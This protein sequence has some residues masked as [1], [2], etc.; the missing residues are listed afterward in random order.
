MIGLVLTSVIL[1]VF[2]TRFILPASAVSVADSPP[3]EVFA[4]RLITA[5]KQ[6][7]SLWALRQT[8]HQ[9]KRVVLIFHGNG[10]TLGSSLGIQRMFHA[11][12][13]S[14]YA[15]DYRGTGGSSGRPSEAGL[16]LD[17]DAAY[18]FVT[19]NE[20]VSPENVVLMGYSFG[21]GIAS[22]LSSSH[23]N[24]AL[25]LIA[26]YTSMPDAVAD[27]AWF[28]LLRPFV[29]FKLPTQEYLSRT[30]AKCVMIAH[31][32]SD[33]VIKVEHSYRLLQRH[34]GSPGF[35]GIIVPGASHWD[36]L[37]RAWEQI[38]GKLQECTS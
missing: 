8:S 3:N 36:I 15:I 38:L 16:Y 26:P 12:G 11:A 31:G 10:D 6:H 4:T 19:Q 32:T 17:A 14:T 27:R 34:A 1:V 30:Q 28:R 24:A 7:I 21:S 13:Y 23:R 29:R 18:H 35:T 22:Y 2:Q 5:D 33:N 9:P 37:S 25:L 20:G